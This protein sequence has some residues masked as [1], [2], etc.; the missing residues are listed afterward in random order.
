MYGLLVQQKLSELEAAKRRQ[1]AQK[2]VRVPLLL[3]L[4]LSSSA[5]AG[6]RPSG[7]GGEGGEE[8]ED[9]VPLPGRQVSTVPAPTESKP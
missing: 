4:T 2:K 8:A 7:A 5:V 3:P 9:L 6:S 1:R